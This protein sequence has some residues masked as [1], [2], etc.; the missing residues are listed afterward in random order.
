MTEL[1]G[2]E[3]VNVIRVAHTR[4]DGYSSPIRIVTEYFSK[5]GTLLAENDPNPVRDETIKAI[6]ADRDHAIE[7]HEFCLK[8]KLLAQNENE[9]LRLLL[10]PSRFLVS[11]AEFIKGIWPKRAIAQL[12]KAIT[13]W[14]NFE[15]ATKAEASAK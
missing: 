1:R 4:G 12:R 8:Q 15:R 2:V 5:E 6:T 13:A 11:K 9:V 10:G 3:L 7:Q 14:D